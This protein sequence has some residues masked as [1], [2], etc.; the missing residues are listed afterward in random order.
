MVRKFTIT[1]LIVIEYG[2]VVFSLVFICYILIGVINHFIIKNKI[3]NDFVR[4]SVKQYYHNIDTKYIKK[5]LI[6]SGSRI[7]PEVSEDL[8]EFTLN[9]LKK[10]GVQILLKNRV[11]EI[12]QNYVLLNKGGGDRG[13]EETISSNTVIWAG[14]VKP[15]KVIVG[16]TCQH[17]KSRKIITNENLKVN[18]YSNIFALGDCAFVVDPNTGKPYPP[19]AQHALR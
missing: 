9:K 13:E 19:T 11:K 16:L 10:N 14:G 8:S 18:G 1:R 5:I 17:D 3:L 6:N 15:N 12:G 7:L 2:F 4:D